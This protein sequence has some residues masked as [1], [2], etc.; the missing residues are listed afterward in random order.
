MLA[1]R[2]HVSRKH[3]ECYYTST[4]D[5]TMPT[6]TSV[7]L[8]SVPMAA[9]H[10]QR[11][12]TMQ[13]SCFHHLQKSPHLRRFCYSISASPP[14]PIPHLPPLFFFFCIPPIPAP[15]SSAL[16]A[17]TFHAV[18]LSADSPPHPGTGPQFPRQLYNCFGCVP[19]ATGYRS[20]IDVKRN[21][22]EAR[23]CRGLHMVPHA[24]SRE[25]V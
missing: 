17:V 11:S 1:G 16:F 19:S 23:R 18:Y 10:P 15:L 22:Y 9:I 8:K 14:L 12:H 5:A 3:K 2:D 24:A 13:I 21:M 4:S 7:C 6:S 25:A 20:I